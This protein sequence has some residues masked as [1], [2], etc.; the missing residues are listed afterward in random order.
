M[1]L[2]MLV[3]KDKFEL[4]IAVAESTRELAMMLGVSPNIV[5]SSYSKKYSNWKKVEI[6]DEGDDPWK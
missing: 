1:T 5:S 6:E 2:Y 4:P 3:T